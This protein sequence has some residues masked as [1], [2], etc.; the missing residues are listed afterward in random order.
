MATT[1]SINAPSVNH[2]LNVGTG[3][4][5]T[6][7][8]TGSALQVLQSGGAS[9]NPSFSTATYPA[10]AGT[11]GNVLTSDGTNWISSPPASV[12]SIWTT[13]T[14]D[15]TAVANNGYFV[16]APGINFT[17]TLPAS[18]TVG[19]V[20]AFIVLTGTSNDIFI[21][22]NTGQFIRFGTA[23]SVSGGT[24]DSATAGDTLFLYYSD[25]DTTWYSTNS[26]GTWIIT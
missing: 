16:L 2:T 23:L 17:V 21:Q 14:T 26:T 22:A 5:Y 9:A 18:P 6:A 1:N 24:A 7:L 8:S 10:T 20:V 13:Q 4:G 3:S 19:N 25:S 12:P 15:F 11:D